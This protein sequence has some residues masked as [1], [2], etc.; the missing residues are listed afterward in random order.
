MKHLIITTIAAVLLVGCG[1]SK[2]FTEIISTPWTWIGI[3]ANLGIV[4]PVVLVIILVGYFL[5][6]FLFRKHG[7]KTGEELKAEGK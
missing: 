2:S 5:G 3:L 4:L 1:G 7:G 6:K